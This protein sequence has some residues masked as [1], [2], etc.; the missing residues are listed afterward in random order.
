M[1][2]IAF[3]DG[4]TYSLETPNI[5]HEQPANLAQ[6]GEAMEHVLGA[7]EKPEDVRGHY[8]KNY[9]DRQAKEGFIEVAPCKFYAT[10]AIVSVEVVDADRA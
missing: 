3:S 7:A 6:L 2:K 8:I 9:L 10:S 1:L 4:K 5:A